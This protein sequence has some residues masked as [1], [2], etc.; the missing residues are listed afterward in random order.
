MSVLGVVLAVVGIIAAFI[1]TVL[2]GW[3]GGAVAAAFGVIGVLLGFR[4]R[5]N[6]EKQKGMGAIVTGIIAVVLAV[7]MIFTMQSAMKTIKDKLLE[8]LEKQGGSGKFPTV[9]KYAESA[10]TSTGFIGLVNSMATK[11]TEEDKSKFEEEIKN[12][13]DL[14]SDSSSSSDN[15]KK[16]EPKEAPAEE[17]TPALDPQTDPDAG[18]V[19]ETEPDAGTETD[20]DTETKT[21]DADTQP[22]G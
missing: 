12:L 11:V 20:S 14:L 10:D 13:T 7:V 6:S 17:P 18:T 8:E 21:E 22:E 19:T 3:I 1:G 5:K 16:E 2:F 4:A 9:A 15:N